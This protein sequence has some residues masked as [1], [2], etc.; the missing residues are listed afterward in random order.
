[1]HYS[2]VYF[3]FPVAIFQVGDDRLTRVCSRRLTGMALRMQAVLRE[4]IAALSGLSM[5]MRIALHVGSCMGG[6]GMP[7]STHTLV[8]GRICVH[9][10]RTLSSAFS[11]L[12]A[13]M[14][15][16]SEGDAA[17][18]LLLLLLPL[19]PST[20][21]Q[22]SPLLEAFVTERS[23]CVSICTVVLAEPA[24][25]CRRQERMRQYL[26][27]C[28]RSACVS[29]CTVVLAEPAFACRRQSSPPLA[30]SSFD[31]F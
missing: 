3:K 13:H 7:Y 20:R 5:N 19:S 1:V 23:A 2:D 14:C 25:A 18:L 28:T 10:H 6:I 12:S 11:L 31:L 21:R 17:P 30:Y 26:Y 27:C 16:S 15:A 24:F 9:T 29:I 4:G 8:T 22:P